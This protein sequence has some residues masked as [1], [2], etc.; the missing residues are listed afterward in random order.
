MDGLLANRKSKTSSIFEHK[1]AKPG[2]YCV[3]PSAK[4][5]NTNSSTSIGSVFSMDVAL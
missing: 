5:R 3:M 4:Y 1:H 2:F